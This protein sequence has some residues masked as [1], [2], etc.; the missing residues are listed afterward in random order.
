MFELFLT[1]KK[2]FLFY[3]R[4]LKNMITDLLIDLINYNKLSV[5]LNDIL[6]IININFYFKKII[7]ILLQLNSFD[8]YSLHINLFLNNIVDF[9]QS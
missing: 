4:S 9:T 5:L 2:A 7:I 6:L 8:F 1:K 3:F